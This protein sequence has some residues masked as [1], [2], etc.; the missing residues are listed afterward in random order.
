MAKFRKSQS[1]KNMRQGAYE[2]M[3]DSLMEVS[4]LSDEQ[5]VDRI[6]KLNAFTY[7]RPEGQTREQLI[8]GYAM[9][10]ARQVRGD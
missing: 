4:S 5:I 1:T 10:L 6:G 9:A 7:V 8:I 3:H 2:R